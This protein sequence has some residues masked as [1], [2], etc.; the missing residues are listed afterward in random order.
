MQKMAMMK[1]K[2]TANNVSTVMISTRFDEAA[3]KKMIMNLRILSRL[4]SDRYIFMVK[5]DG[6]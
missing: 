5:P 6:G 1:K 4:V 3:R 2:T